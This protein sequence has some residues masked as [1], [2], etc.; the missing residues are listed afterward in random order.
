MTAYFEIRFRE[1]CTGTVV[2]GYPDVSVS[3]EMEAREVH[4]F[5]KRL[6]TEMYGAEAK[7][8]LLEVN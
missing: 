3:S 8:V 5:Y 7:A 2:C 6:M 1:P 4:E